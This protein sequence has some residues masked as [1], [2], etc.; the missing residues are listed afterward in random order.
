MKLILLHF[1]IAMIIVSCKQA[2]KKE[3]IDYSGFTDREI[4]LAG[5]DERP[6]WNDS[7]ARVSLKI[8]IRL[9]T[10]YKWQH[11]SCNTSSGWMKYRFADKSYP[12]FAESGWYWPGPDSVYQL[13]IWHKPIKIAPDSITL[14]PL[15][16]NDTP[17]CYYHPQIVGYS[18]SVNF[19]FKEFK[20]INE[21]P[22]VISAFVCPYGYLTNSQTLF[23][24]AETNLKS[25][26]L[27]FVGECG[28][29]DTTSF[30]GNI[31]KSF[32]SIRIK[33]NP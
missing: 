20:L 6:E 4:S 30:I 11:Y 17:I 33:E 8:P 18:K 13:N 14:K 9:D 7:L 19:L 31:Y 1:V 12:Q 27:Y 16:E 25:R 24:I 21:R 5:Y 15:L 2:D 22:F 10:F 28:A 3:Q 26:E 29:K 23:I 32:L